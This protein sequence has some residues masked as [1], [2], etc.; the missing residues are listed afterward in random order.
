MAH[1]LVFQT[2][3]I[4]PIQ[5]TFGN[6]PAVKRLGLNPADGHRTNHMPVAVEELANPGWLSERPG[7]AV[8]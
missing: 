1:P 5:L 3:L 4:D 7:N 8:L 6:L 2:F